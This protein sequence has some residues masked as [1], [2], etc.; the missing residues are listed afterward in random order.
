MKEEKCRVVENININEKY[1]LMKLKTT[2]I[3]KDCRPGNFVMVAVSTTF[4]PLLK[5][6]FGIFKSEPPY[7]Y[8]YYEV[9]GKGSELMSRLKENDNLAVLGP[10][11]NSFPVF[12]SENIL[13]I[14]GG[15]GIVPI[16]FAAENY[17]AGNTL[18]LIYGAKSAGDLNLLD[19]IDSLPLKKT[20][21][22]SENGS[23]GKKGLVT[24]DVREII[25]DNHINITFSCGPD[26]MFKS[27]NQ[28]LAGLAVENYASL[29]ALMGCGFGICYSCAV[30]TRLGGYKKV[31][32]DGPVFKLEDIE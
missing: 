8:L 15:R 3:A 10:L 19:R 4:D 12:R 13:L 9:V 5:R 18:F 29:E 23:T 1:S 7:I 30:K 21:L 22:Y 26:A 11:G 14:A 2:T 17:A 6:P 24:G 31:C 16:Y 28:E 25:I 27:L 20:Y 32:S